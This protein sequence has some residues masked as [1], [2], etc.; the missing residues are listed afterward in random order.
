VA[1]PW[2][3]RYLS[4]RRRPWLVPA[5]LLTVVA[6]VF[7]VGAVAGQA[8]FDTTDVGL[9][10]DWVVAP[11]I[12]GYGWALLLLL[13]SDALLCL[14]R[15]TP[16][17]RTLLL[18]GVMGIGLLSAVLG[19][20]ESAGR[21]HIGPA[22][23][24]AVAAVQPPVGA[25]PLTSLQLAYDDLDGTVELTQG[26]PEPSA[27]KSWQAPG[28][29][30]DELC[31][32]IARMVAGQPG[33]HPWVGCGYQRAQGRVSVVIDEDTVAANQHREVIDVTAAPND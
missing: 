24:A 19:I 9:Y 27:S 30:R 28:A 21:H 2:P 26:F 32:M 20:R 10:T 16:R 18:A 8:W 29:T 5:G 13:A 22:L 12:S 23:L 6:G 15:W 7:W 31:Q 11:L 1:Q 17:I 4:G 33:W 14:R 3:R 25:V